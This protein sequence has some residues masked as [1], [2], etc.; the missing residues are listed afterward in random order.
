MLL[1]LLAVILV[2]LF[3]KSFVPGYV[4]FSNDGPLAQQV[5]P[6]SQ[7]PGA[8]SGTWADLN[9]LG[10][11]S[12]A[13]S[14]SIV[15]FIHLIL[16]PIGYSKF[17]A[18]IAMFILGLC[19]WIFFRQL[20]LSPLAAALGGLAAG[21]QSA[22][23]SNACWGVAS[24]AI[25]VGMTYLALALVVSNTPKTPMLVRWTRIALAGLAVG[26]NVIE[27]ADNGAIFSLFI[28]AFVLVKAL[29][30]EG[31]SI[32]LKA[33]GGVIRII[34]I[35][36]FAGFIAAQTIASLIGTSIVGIAGTAQ[37]P[38]AKAAQW[39]FA[40]QWSLPK[41][42]TLG[43]FVPGLFGYRMDTP[44]DAT[45]VGKN[46]TG[47]A[48]WGAMGRSQE[49]DRYFAAG[50]QGPEPNQN[51]FFIRQ[52]GGGIYLGIV[53]SVIAIWAIAQAFRRKNSVFSEMQKKF[54]WFWTA[55]CV[56]SIL[57]AWGRWAP[58]YQF[59][60]ALPYS[61]TIR[62]PT[63]FISVFGWA[64]LIIFAYGVHGLSR[65]YLEVPGNHLKSSISEFQS[66]WKNARDFDRRWTIICG[67]VFALS[68]IAWLIYASEKSAL[69]RYLA[70]MHPPG[71]PDQI[72]SFSIAQAGWFLLYFAMVIAI[73]ILI[74]A[75]IFSGKRA[76]TGGILLGI[77]LLADFMRADMPYI[78]HWNY[79]VKYAN[80]PII[81]DYLENKSYEH[82]VTNLPFHAAPHLPQYDDYWEDLYR[83]EWI[84]QLFPFYN[85]QSLD[86]V[87]LPRM[88]V[89]LEAYLRAVS[90][91]PARYWELSNSRYLLGP[92]AIQIPQSAGPN[93]EM[94]NVSTLSFLNDALDSEQKRFRIVQRFDVVPKEGVEQ[95][96]ELEQFTV[97]T[98]DGGGCALFE[99]TG[100]LPR[101]KL[102]S[103]WETNNVDEI[104]DF[105][106]NGLSDNDLTI[107][108]N[109]GTN[110]FLTLKKLATPAFDPQKTVLLDA[111]LSVNPTGATN[112]GTVN[113]ESYSSKDI[114]LKANV[115]AP[116]VLLYNDK[117]DPHWDVAVDG[118]P[119]K[120]FRANFIMRGV[121]VPA[122]AHTVEFRFNVPN[123]L[124]YITLTAIGVGI[125]LSGLLFLL[126][127]RATIRETE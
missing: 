111:P 62:N 52:T 9:V 96:H 79:P 32:W 85:V 23:F 63:K 41:V 126:G 53:L 115:L 80:N 118:K 73:S 127:R 13:I 30:E 81:Q 86:I 109:A 2:A 34:V 105:T 47:G 24:Q 59:F 76:K 46:Y 104:K 67:I 51:Y 20:K 90:S 39:D 92:M 22:W 18:P 124:L 12:G 103:D 38:E 110:G 29:S 58:F 31:H 4:H 61:S 72:A 94:I 120:L 123:K 1:L 8:F 6:W 122:G 54:L 57:L 27:G 33:G 68:V 65:R 121:F 84:Q 15:S 49:W 16:G 7:L 37:T 45:W 48:Y 112:A 95:I 75:G 89:D 119:T 106:T 97:V 102:Y 21:L 28:A 35:A 117:Y 3:W 43:L 42:E 77:L 5:T 60:Y 69:V 114:R 50:R 74:I 107:L 93:S 98:N 82:R 66:W 11:S 64:W 108:N 70:A 88:P 125:L 40:T 26:A 99:F 10:N 14:P 17:L 83:I 44:K 100:A 71:D 19:A 25:A 55:I 36:V 56:L 101:V 116:S 91:L 78:V 113:F 87:M